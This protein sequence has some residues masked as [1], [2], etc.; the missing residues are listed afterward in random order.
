MSGIGTAD[1]EVRRELQY[2]QAG[3]GE[4]MTVAYVNAVESGGVVVSG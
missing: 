2:N 4:A 3:T 1:Y